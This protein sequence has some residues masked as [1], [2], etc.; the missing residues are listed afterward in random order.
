MSDIARYTLPGS[1]A[2]RVVLRG[3]D[4][5]ALTG[6][7]YAGLVL[8]VAGLYPVYY[9]L[10]VR[11]E[12]GAV[13]AAAIAFVGGGLMWKLSRKRR[14]N[15]ERRTV[16]D[17]SAL[18][19]WTESAGEATAALNF[20]ELGT[21]KLGS[22][23]LYNARKRSTNKVA[24]VTLSDHDDY[25]LYIPWNNADMVRYVNALRALVGEQYLPRAEKKAG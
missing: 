11:F 17:L 10:S 4:V 20:T 22:V 16:V 13:V 23:S 2:T 15:P 9:L 7:S 5:V 12:V 8:M 14:A 21:L 19:L 3:A 6:V 1:T 18:Q 24:A 25:V